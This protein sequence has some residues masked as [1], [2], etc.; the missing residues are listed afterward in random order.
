M[1]HNLQS[2]RRML[3]VQNAGERDYRGEFMSRKRPTSHKCMADLHHNTPLPSH[4]LFKMPVCV[5]RLIMLN[6]VGQLC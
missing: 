4:S 1:P 3:V 6:Y 5:G 2:S